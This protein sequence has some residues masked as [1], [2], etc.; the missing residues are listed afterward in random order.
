MDRK[1]QIFISS[2]YT[3]LKEDRQIAVEAI[4]SARHIPAGMELFSAGSES[5][6]TVI[7]RWI[8]E[9][10][11]FM[12]ILGG[13]YGSIEPKSG[14]SYTQLEYE[15]AVS[16][17]KPFF[18]IVMSEPL[19]NE[20]IKKFGKD[21]FE[22]ENPKAYT[23]FKNLVLSKQ[24]K[25]YDEPKDIKIAILETLN[26]FSHKYKLS[27]WVS[28]KDALT[29]NLYI[30][31]LAKLS[32]E[33]KSLREQVEY[34]KSE[35]DVNKIVL[36]T[37]KEKIYFAK[38]SLSDR[39]ERILKLK[40]YDEILIEPIGWVVD[41]DDEADN[42]KTKEI[43]Y[44]IPNVTTD[45]YPHFVYESNKRDYFNCIAFILID[46]GIDA[47]NLSESFS[48]IRMQI[49]K[50]PDNCSMEFKFII[51]SERIS[52]SLMKQCDSNFDRILKKL[53][54]KNSSDILFEIWDTSKILKF[55]DELGLNY[56]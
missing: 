43:E 47:L 50:I 1:Y 51:I 13:R 7:K 12:L 32:E 20:R 54:K 8:D 31:E 16:A 45:F 40:Y 35:L 28:G 15:F 24:S 53:A 55:E 9:S 46:D 36:P 42:G 26:D 3:D 27:G 30:D 37:N 33:N 11:I 6:L 39:I 21:V 29:N 41:A 38:E 4:L 19:L 14:K 48:S 2:T 52:D 5:Q 44:N 23:K 18:A 49:E 10:D 34:Y 17:G 22:S 56:L 25:F